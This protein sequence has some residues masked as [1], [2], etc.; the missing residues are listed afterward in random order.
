M[1]PNKSVETERDEHG[2]FLPG[3]PGGPGRPRFSLISIIREKLL[4]V[5]KGEVRSRAELLLDAYIEDAELR[6]DGIAIR[7]LI[8]RFDGKA[9]QTI[10]V[11]SEQDAAWL[12]FLKGVRAE[13]ECEAENDPAGILEDGTEAA[14]P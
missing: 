13:P 14:R 12:E 10:T 4:E 9:H 3:N 2:R 1:V 11:D 8:D 5:P 6:K 7:D